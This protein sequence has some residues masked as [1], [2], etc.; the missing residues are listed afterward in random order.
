MLKTP[1]FTG[2]PGGIRN[3]DGRPLDRLFR[4]SGNNTGNFLF[5]SALRNMLGYNEDIF[6]PQ[7][8]P[9]RQIEECDFLAISAA[10]WVNPN[11]DLSNL[12]T[13]IESS[14]LPCVVV[15]LGAQ[16]KFDEDLPELKEGTKRFLRVVSDRSDCI[17]VRGEFTKYVL[18][19]YG[20]KNTFVTGCPSLIGAKPDFSPDKISCNDLVD[21]DR[22]VLQGARHNE[23]PA[24]FNEDK[25][26]QINLQIYR[27]AIR[28]GNPLLL[29]SE[30]PD[31]LL[32]HG[33][34]DES[35][36]K[37]A[38][39]RYLERVYQRDFDEIAG[40]LIDNSMVFWNLES[41]FQRLS[42]Y[43][44]LIGNRIHGVVSG[45]LSGV[46]SVLLARD[47][48][49]LEL[50]RYMN[51]PYQ[52]MRTIDKFDSNLLENVVASFDVGGFADGFQAY[53]DNF[54]DFFEKNDIY[55]C[56]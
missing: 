46:P 32:K 45:L 34:L 4:S 14:S 13:F 7:T 39:V 19:Q 47:H 54:R 33:S 48:R 51:L 11:V 29:Q 42:K 18:E 44:F 43:P 17:S 15:G 16:V 27:F 36:K 56:F 38:Y 28:H 9:L 53:K 5:V 2:I 10:N 1:F 49:T 12:A 3:P 23:S 35:N 8:Q 55:T 31:M 40:Y 21:L 24:V 26:S 20:V 50:A 6:R 25:V 22:V 52:D 37:N 41:W 30:L